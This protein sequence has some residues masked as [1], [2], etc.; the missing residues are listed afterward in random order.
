MLL[1][2]SSKSPWP[3][4]GSEAKVVRLVG[5]NNGDT[6]LQDLLTDTNDVI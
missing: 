5:D 4:T 2:R 6:P 3:V 1:L